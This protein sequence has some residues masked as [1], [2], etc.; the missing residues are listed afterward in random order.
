LAAEKGLSRGI[1]TP[2]TRYSVFQASEPLQKLERTKAFLVS[3]FTPH[4]NEKGT[5]GRVL[6]SKIHYPLPYHDLRSQVRELIKSQKTLYR[7]NIKRHSIPSHHMRHLTETEKQG[8]LFSTDWMDLAVPSY[9][10]EPTWNQHWHTKH[11]H[12]TNM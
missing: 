6:P 8:L 11:S 2:R 1:Y 4:L 10:S 12:E 9:L 5:K 3:L 7:Y